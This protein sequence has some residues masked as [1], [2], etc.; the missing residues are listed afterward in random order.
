MF[1]NARG[2]HETFH[3]L[4]RDLFGMTAQDEVNLVR[5]AID[6]GKQSLQIDRAAGTG[7][8]N[9]QFHAP[10]QSHSAKKH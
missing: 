5:G 6:L 4:G 3:L 2:N 7:G 10:N 9:D 1:G 8:G